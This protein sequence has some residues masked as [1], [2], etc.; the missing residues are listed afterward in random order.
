MPIF[1]TKPAP[2][3]PGLDPAGTPSAPVKGAC[4]ITNLPPFV[5]E[6]DEFGELTDP[7]GWDSFDT[8]RTLYNTLLE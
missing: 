2:G 3:R 5:Y 6:H 7:K 8:A 4:A 1:C